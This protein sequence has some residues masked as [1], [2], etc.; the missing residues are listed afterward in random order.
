L[1]DSR[2]S[3][4]STFAGASVRDR[5]VQAL[6][7]ELLGPEAADEVLSQ[8]PA[9]RYLVG[10]LAPM[11]TQLDP[12]ED[13]KLDAGDDQS[14]P[15]IVPSMTLSLAQ[16]S[17]GLSFV[18]G[19]DTNSV[20]V[21]VTWGEYHKIERPEAVLAEAAGDLDRDADPELTVKKKR[22]DYQWHRTLQ[23]FAVPLAIDRE[24]RQP[25]VTI[26]DDIRLDSMVRPLGDK[27]VVSIFL[28]NGRRSAAGR[29]PPDELWLYQPSVRV[30]GNGECFHARQIDRDRPDDDPDIASAD[31]VYR[32]RIEYATGH[33]AAP[34]WKPPR[35]NAAKTSEI[36]TEVV[37]HQEVAQVV[38]WVPPGTPE[39]DMRTLARAERPEQIGELVAPLLG[40][41]ESWIGE[42]A[43][44][45][46]T[47]GPAF[48][49]VAQDHVALARSCLRRI[50]RGLTLLVEDPNAFRAFLFANRAMQLQRQATV[51]VLAL[52]RGEPIP[53]TVGAS[54]RPFQ[55]GFIL[56]CLRG[57]ADPSDDERDIADLLWFP[58]GGGKTEAYLGLTAFTLAY[59]RMRSKTDPDDSSCGT[60]VVMRYTLRLLTIQ[61]FQRAAALICACEVIRLKDPAQWGDEPFTIGLW[62]GASVTPNSYEDAKAAIVRLKNGETLYE[63]SPYQVLYC[64][65][66]GRDLPPD[67][68]TSDDD[69]ERTLVKCSGEGCPFAM[70]ASELGLPVLLVDEEIYRHPPS[71]L[72]ATVDKFAQMAWNGRI[73]SLFGRVTDRCPRHGFISA[74]DQH[75]KRHNETR[76]WPKAEIGPARRLAPP[77]LIIQDELHL[78]SGPLGTLVGIYE[79]AVE[80]L[81]S[82]VLHGKRVRAKVV[83]STATIRRASKQVAALF[84]RD[85][86]VFPPQGLDAGD[87]FFARE[88]TSVPGRL[89]LGVYAPGKSV[90]T[91]LVRVY[92]TAL[93]RALVEFEAGPSP[94][95]DS[96]M[97]LVGYFN[98]LREL[99]GA[100]R[101]V[102]DDVPARLRVLRRRGFGPARLIYEKKELTSRARSQEISATLKQLDRTFL[103]KESGAYPIDILL[104][105]NML[106]VGV[107]IDRLGIMVVSAQPK[108]SAEYIQATSRVGRRHPGLVI[109]VYNW[110][111]PRDTSHYERFA[112]YHDTFYRHVEATSVTP[113]SARARDRA[114][115]GVLVSYL[116]QDNPGLATEQ[117]ANLFDATSDSVAKVIAELVG[118]AYRVT[119][120]EEVRSE[121]DQQ[122]KN[123]VAEWR[124]QTAPPAARS[125][126]YTGR[127]IKRDD[128]SKSILLQPMERE[129]GRGMWRVAGSLREVEPELPV[130]LIADSDT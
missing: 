114:L 122:L 49:P 125:L 52:R 61:Q 38:P 20:E 40:A 59:R 37:P 22:K 91:S 65:W 115:A 10:M 27:R 77:D 79:S 92:A 106:S 26:R 45:A 9:T 50:T 42:L 128:G 46:E 113:F 89:Y 123:L 55:L 60:S 84:D 17:I 15:E 39:F 72:L 120:R 54:W 85:V 36:W 104:A 14:S 87:S 2:D 90:K 78:I 98:S 16:S 23:R 8:S 108:T 13:E 71:V 64:P 118:R 21:E 5:L 109:E 110:S 80:G 66:C 67:H 119:E 34:A 99:G 101:L 53:S 103:G 124:H 56:Q 32:G 82:R 73:Q 30:R 63:A 86:C 121:T 24:G 76:G 19:S 96:Y 47:L 1:S 112:H 11:N 35:D 102:D 97:T 107:D 57:I 69:L 93:S 129:L 68:Y 95:S 100:V 48:R 43:N 94:E 70:T 7:F 3:Q 33:G 6:R 31:L 44:L 116:R 4:Y 83:A 130:V 18:V 111:R 88:D 41:Y 29:R 126:V 62:V 127:G 28:V 58:T 51:T 25:P 12:T 74:G 81:S 75:P 105:S 117:A